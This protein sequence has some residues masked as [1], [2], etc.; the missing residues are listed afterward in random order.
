MS[1]PRRKR[2]RQYLEPGQPWDVPRQTAYNDELKRARR[3]HASN[4]DS[5]TQG[6]ESDHAHGSRCSDS[7]SHSGDDTSCVDGSEAPDDFFDCH[8][9]AIGDVDHPVGSK[10]VEL[11][12]NGHPANEDEM[13]SVS[14]VGG[15]AEDS[16]PNSGESTSFTDVGERS[17]GGTP[18]T[19]EW[20]S[21]SEAGESGEGGPPNEEEPASFRERDENFRRYF[22]E[23]AKETLPNRA[24]NKAQA[25][26]LILTYVVHAGLSWTQVEGLLKLINTLCGSDVLPDTTHM[27]RKMWE[28]EMDSLQ[29]HFF[30]QVCFGYFGS[31]GR[32]ETT[33]TFT[34][35]HCNTTQ[36][37]RRLI[38]RG[39]FFLIFNL[40]EQIY[41]I[42]SQ[43][44]GLLFHR[45]KQ[46]ASTVPS[47]YADITDGRLYRSTR[48]QLKAKW[49]DLTVT[50]N[51]D[52]SP[53]FKSSKASVW[54]VQLLIN[55]LP[56]NIRF[57]NV[58]VGALWFAKT[59]PPQH[60]FMKAFVKAF[61]DIGTIV[62][63]HASE[64]VLS[65][66]TVACC[67]VDSPAR[68]SLLN[69]KQFNGYFGCSWCLQ[70]GTAVDGTCNLCEAA[71]CARFGISK[72]LS[73]QRH[74][75]TLTCVKTC[76]LPTDSARPCVG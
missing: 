21:F 36:T 34:C 39:D 50:M 60:L 27:L 8:E 40:K 24:I 1:T 64:T 11:C 2:Y 4:V 5:A 59:H 22:E 74:A 9:Q 68:A 71:T 75:R 3:A 28:T 32:K 67:C 53:V 45:L 38:A 65:R 63:K 72:E 61:N 42:V 7:S 25:I 51:T 52:G 54:P 73:Q 58:I 12:N 16:P 46:M 15:S 31:K 56:F 37:V 23:C 18:N 13:A 48:S 44:S 26:L 19:D 33:H 10:P 35:M 43:Y 55:E 57:R 14:D 20:A 69:M 70:K 41:D 76:S 49:S 66:L 29:V 30:C 62:W 6:D 47:M 17:E